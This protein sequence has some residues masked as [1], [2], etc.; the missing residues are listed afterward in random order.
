MENLRYKS[1]NV[2]KFGTGVLT[3]QGT[4]QINEPQLDALTSAIA[5]AH[6]GGHCCILVSSGAVGAGISAFS[7]AGRPDDTVIQ[8]A[9][10]AVGQTRLMHTYEKFFSRYD[11]H[12]AQLLV[13]HADFH[14]QTRRKNFHQ[15][16]EKLLEFPCVIPVINENDS[17]A[18]EELRFGDN[19]IL[20]ADVAQLVRADLLLLLTS[21]DGLHNTDG[22]MIAQVDDIDSISHLAHG[23]TGK[24]SVGGMQTK[25]EAVRSAVTA[26]IG[27]AIANGHNPHQ[28]PE[29]ILGGG[30]CTRFSAQHSHN[31]LS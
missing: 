21:V 2:I 25:L 31:P 9:C 13:T 5:Q 22:S 15:T 24:L 26:G 1:T 16:L 23:N 11:L 19:D 27:A 20:S 29:L 17:V 8:Q 28:I 10:A 7:L 12:V 18:T 4:G 6:R 30:T 3:H 14:T